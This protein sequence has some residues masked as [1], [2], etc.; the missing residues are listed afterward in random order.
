MNPNNNIPFCEKYRPKY[1]NEIESTNIQ[2]LNKIIDSNKLPHMLF[3]GPSGT[4][5]TSTIM[6]CALKLYGENYKN[7]ILEL[8]GSDDRGI[9]VVRQNIKE[10]VST[11]RLFKDGIKLVIL[12]E[13]DSMTYDAQFALRR[14]IETYTYNA[15]F[16]LICNYINKI[17]PAL[18]SRCIRFKFCAVPNISVK[19]KLNQI[20]ENESIDIEESAID[21]MIDISEGDLRKAINMLQ[22]ISSLKVNIDDDKVYKFLGYPSESSIQKIWNLLNS[23]KLEIV[24]INNII[25]EK[26]YLLKEIITEIVKILIKP[27]NLN[28]SIDLMIDRKIKI[29]K[30]LANL[31]DKLA[32]AE[33]IDLYISAFVAIFH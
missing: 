28:G 18:Q 13:V 14:V 19:S 9:N 17:I 20:I 2:I 3:Y 4:G 23:Q 7:M 22:I 31:E 6:A 11:N 24:K 26:G 16:C 30:E 12:D 27:N 25:K 10:F 15:R 5:K 1:L 29:L 32:N 21:V 33:F 8:N